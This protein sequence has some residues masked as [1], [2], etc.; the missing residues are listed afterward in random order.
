MIKTGGEL[1]LPAMPQCYLELWRRIVWPKA[2]KHHGGDD[3]KG[4]TLDK[5]V[6]STDTELERIKKFGPT[7]DWMRLTPEAKAQELRLES[8]EDYL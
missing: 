1:H 6:L 8:G 2:L 5:K 4:S 7:W 3:L